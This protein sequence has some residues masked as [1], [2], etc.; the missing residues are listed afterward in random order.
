MR[1]HSGSYQRPMPNSDPYSASRIGRGVSYLVAGKLATSVAGIGTFLLLVR[2]LSIGEFAA[3]TILFALV[4]IVDAVSGV[5][6]SHVVARYVPELFVQRQG[7]TL[8]RL[9][10]YALSI[11]VAVLAALLGSI[12]ALAS[13][14]APLVGL[15]GWD[16]ALRAYL[17]VVL[18]RVLNA[19]VVSVLESLLHQKI[20]QLTL[21]LVNATRFALLLG[22][23]Y[24]D[25]FDLQTVIAIE[26][27]TEA[28]GSIFVLTGMLKVLQ[29]SATEGGEESGWIRSNLD[30][31]SRFGVKGYLQHLLI[32]PYGGSTNRI[33]VGGSLATANVA[34]FGFAQSVADLLEKY[35]PVRLLAGV[36]RPVLTARYVRDRLFGEIELAANAI[37]KVNVITIYL[38]AVTIFAGGQELIDVATAGKYGSKA[39]GL[40]LLMCAIVILFSVRHMLDQVSHAVEQNGPLLWSNAV[41]T[42]SIVPGILLLPF[43]GV[44]ALP[45]ANSVGL[46]IGIGVFGWRLR[47]SGFPYRHD[48]PGHAKLLAAAALAC[49]IAALLRKSGIGW[50]PSLGVSVTT[51][52]GLAIVL[53][54]WSSAERR[55]LVAMMGR[56]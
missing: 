41:I 4:E 51:Y 52:A 24:W 25:S 48:F 55:A 12:F 35:L 19:S 37:V 23:A 5:G 2:E 22:F 40:L 54:P 18:F 13:G 38:V 43:L 9:V 6:L 39:V 49:S 17:L 32:M 3:Y 10:L 50:I 11:R 34:V 16:W 46:V 8:R 33:L 27:A 28:L 1:R 31:I 14:L 47:V 30:R 36:I 56:R 21:V 45:F 20:A 44:Y 53:R 42:A 7:A 29:E 15:E 26:L